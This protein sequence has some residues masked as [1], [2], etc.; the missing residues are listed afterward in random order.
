MLAPTLLACIVQIAAV[1][2]CKNSDK[3][4]MQDANLQQKDDNLSKRNLKR[5]I[6]KQGHLGTSLLGIIESRPE[7][8]FLNKSVFYY[9]TLSFELL[10]VYLSFV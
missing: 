10:C 4:T 5:V 2:E 1:Q 9:L 3:Q 7:T 6:I 8:D